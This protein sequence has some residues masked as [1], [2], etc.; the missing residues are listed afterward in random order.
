MNKSFY[1]QNLSSTFI[2]CQNFTFSMNGGHHYALP[3]NL[4]SNLR[5]VINFNF[6]ITNATFEYLCDPTPLTS[7]FTDVR[8]VDSALIRLKNVS[9]RRGWNWTPFVKLKGVKEA[10]ID[11]IIEDS[12]LR[13][14]TSD[15]SNIGNG[16]VETID[17]ANSKLSMIGSSAFETFVNMTHFRVPDN[18][19]SSIRRTDFPKMALKLEE[20]DLR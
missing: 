20:I 14:L 10:H 16:I 7:P 5:L 11:I 4:F 18:K 6:F 12:I 1:F 13:R 8:F 19:I 9:V 3:P 2:P 15:F 17:V